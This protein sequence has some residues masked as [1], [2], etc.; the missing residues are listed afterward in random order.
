MTIP[1]GASSAS[2]SLATIDDAI[3]E[4]AESFSV[5]IG[6]ASGGNF[7]NLSSCPAR[8]FRKTPAT[9]NLQ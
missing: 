4:G 3:V 6:S 9:L 1:A 2:F 5:S 7:E 8:L